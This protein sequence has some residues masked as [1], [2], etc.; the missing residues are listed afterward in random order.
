VTLQEMLLLADGE[1]H[2]HPE[3]YVLQVTFERYL[4]MLVREQREQ[5]ELREKL[6]TPYP[7][8]IGA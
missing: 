8:L 7:E 4:A 1:I 3:Q 5:R 6:G 2:P